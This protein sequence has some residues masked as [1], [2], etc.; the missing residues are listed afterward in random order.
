METRE[1][2]V[3]FYKKAKNAKNDADKF[4]YKDSV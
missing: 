4:M 1:C 2:F 3:L